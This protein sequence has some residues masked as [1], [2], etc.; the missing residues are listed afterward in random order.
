MDMEVE[1]AF[2][3]IEK[4][5]EEN[6]EE[7]TKNVALKGFRKGK[8][9]KSI[10][11]KN[12]GEEYLFHEALYPVLNATYETLLKEENIEAVSAPYEV[13]V[14]ELA[15]PNPVKFSFKVDILP[16]VKL[17]KYKGLKAKLASAEVTDADIEQELDSLKKNYMTLEESDK[18]IAEGNLVEHIL[19]CADDK[20]EQVE[21]LCKDGYIT[22]IGSEFIS[23][24]FEQSLIGLAKDEEKEFS[25]TVKKDYGEKELAG[26]KLTFKTKITKIH[27]EQYPEL[28]DEFIKKVSGKETLVQFKEDRKAQLVENKA[29]S[30]ENDFLNE[31][32]E[33]LVKENKLAVPP[34]MV[35]KE[36][37]NMISSFELDLQQRYKTNLTDYLKMI[38]KTA[39]EL[40]E[41]Y[42]DNSEKRVKVNLLMA[43][44]VKQEKIEASD[45]EVEKSLGDAVPEQYKDNEA[46]RSY[47]KSMMVDQIKRDK[48]IALLKETAKK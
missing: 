29:Q 13:D 17:K 44:V 34:A 45:E 36:V 30:V 10:F 1:T 4:H 28:D 40:K 22:K 47:Y 24:E 15:K 7:I 5:V 43:E 37:E 14:K 9:P 42:R 38:N 33:E 27:A 41:E 20:G 25:I 2:S 18:A 12:F 32:M 3:E 8:I 35:D 16:E 39:D 21:S 19:E 11:I 26:K 46:V 6:Y 23:A 48:A 31:L